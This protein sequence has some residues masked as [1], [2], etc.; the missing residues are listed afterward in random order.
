MPLW[1]PTRKFTRSLWFSNFKRD[2]FFVALTV[3]LQPVCYNWAGGSNRII[4]YETVVP[5][6]ML[7][8][9]DVCP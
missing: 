4:L 9:R 2:L 5:F 1:K 7:H 3:S 6:R 8:V